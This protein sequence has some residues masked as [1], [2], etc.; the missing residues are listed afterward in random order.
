[1]AIVGG[2]IAYLADKIT[3]VKEVFN[4][5]ITGFNEAVRHSAG[6]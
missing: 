2:L 5:L 1:M 6:K 3:T 4:D